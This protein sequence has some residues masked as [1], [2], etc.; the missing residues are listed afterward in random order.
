ML[1]AVCVVLGLV[2]IAG[3]LVGAAFV[4]RYILDWH[5]V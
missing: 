1:S 3:A 5:E 4:R 2:V